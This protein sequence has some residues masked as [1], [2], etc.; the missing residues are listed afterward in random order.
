MI[1][2]QINQNVIANVID[3][4]DITL[5][6]LFAEGFD[7]LL[8]IDGLN[9]VPSMGWI[10]NP[11]TCTFSQPLTQSQSIITDCMIYGNQIVLDWNAMNLVG[12]IYG[13]GQTIP[14]LT[15]V[16][17]LYQLMSLGYLSDAND[18]MTTMIN[19]VSPTKTNLSPFLTN[20]ILYTF[21]IQI[22][23]FLLT[24]PSLE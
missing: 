5:V 18:M 12:N 3:I 20:D 1:Y 13:A 10:Y 23:A 7:L 16:N 22:Q 6:P 9:I 11:V 14:F 17:Q 4:E 21:Q 2:A 19:D 24:L 8:R 15:Y